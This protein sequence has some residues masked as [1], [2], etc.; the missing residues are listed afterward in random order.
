MAGG[1]HV[2]PVY[3]TAND[4]GT[5]DVPEGSSI[6]GELRLAADITSVTVRNSTKFVYVFEFPDKSKI[7]ATFNRVVTPCSIEYRKQ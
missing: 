6:L 3:K 4:V 5:I 2:E 7:E 1:T